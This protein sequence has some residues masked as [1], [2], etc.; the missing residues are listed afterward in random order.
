MTC[1]DGVRQRTTFKL[2]T[3]ASAEAD[4]V[5]G[6]LAL[7]ADEA[8]LAETPQQ[9]NRQASVDDID[10]VIDA[11]LARVA[12]TGEIDEDIMDSLKCLELETSEEELMTLGFKP[13]R[14]LAALDSGAGDHVAGPED[15]AGLQLRES[16]GSRAGRSFIAANGSRI[17]NLGEV[18]LRLRNSNGPIFRSVFQVADV[19]RPLYSVG[20]MCDAGCEIRF[21]KTKAVVT[22]D[23]DVVAVFERQGGLYLAD[24]E[25]L[26]EKGIDEVGTGPFARQGGSK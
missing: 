24:L 7:P 22:K 25:V 18:P 8:L 12:E 19:T 10:T 9:V 17:A 1:M 16:A 14:L 26:A 13:K 20:R 2:M 15:V 6:G 21:T 4:G 5:R 3:T 23:G 11:I